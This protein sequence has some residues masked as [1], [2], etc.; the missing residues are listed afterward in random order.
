MSLAYRLNVVGEEKNLDI[1]HFT[2]VKPSM[3]FL[4]FGVHEGGRMMKIVWN[5]KFHLKLDWPE[6]HSKFFNFW[7]IKIEKLTVI[8]KNLN[9]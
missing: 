8:K 7:A 5:I 3:N 4:F 1:N 6:E 2:K 9:F